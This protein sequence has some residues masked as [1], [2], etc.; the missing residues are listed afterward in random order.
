MSSV[1]DFGAYTPAPIVHARRALKAAIAPS[2]AE[3][4]RPAS[5]IGHVLFAIEYPGTRIQFMDQRQ[6]PTTLGTEG[7]QREFTDSND[8]RPLD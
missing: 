7:V 5:E 2:A 4:P 1:Q 8:T 3:R 6:T